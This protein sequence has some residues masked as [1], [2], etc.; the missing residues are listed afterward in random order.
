MP[1]IGEVIWKADI[2]DMEQG[3]VDTAASMGVYAVANFQCVSQLSLALGEKQKEL[4]NV[5][6]EL[7]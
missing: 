3:A 4:E 7:A 6:H 2:S 1:A 5:K